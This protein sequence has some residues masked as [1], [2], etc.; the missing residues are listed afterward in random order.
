MTKSSAATSMSYSDLLMV[1]DGHGHALKYLSA[2]FSFIC[3]EHLSRTTPDLR[4]EPT[5]S[6]E[7]FPIPGTA[8]QPH[9]RP[10]RILAR[11]RALVRSWGVSVESCNVSMAG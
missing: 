6:A 2:C 4:N 9:Q 1:V 8:G 11:C 7:A 10:S 5:R 3:T